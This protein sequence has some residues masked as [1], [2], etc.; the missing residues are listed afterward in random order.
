[1]EVVG[2]HLV[3]KVLYPNCELCA[4]E[5]RKVLVFLNTSTLDALKWKKIDP[6]FRPP[7]PGKSHTEA[8]S[9]AA[10]FPDTNEGWV[11]ALTY[12]RGKVPV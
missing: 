11:D 10:R 12:A 3:V 8:P 2:P 7:N 1:M 5:G 6:H 9:P 4:Y